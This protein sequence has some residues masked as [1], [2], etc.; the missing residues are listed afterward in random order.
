MVMRY[1]C[2]AVESSLVSPKAPMPYKR[3][4]S[5]S[6]PP[7]LIVSTTPLRN[8]GLAMASPFEAKIKKQEFRKMRLMSSSSIC[9]KSAFLI[10]FVVALL[11]NSANAQKLINDKDG[12]VGKRQYLLSGLFLCI[13]L[14]C[15]LCCIDSNCLC[16]LFL[17]RWHLAWKICLGSSL[18]NAHFFALSN[19]AAV[20]IQSSLRCWMV[21]ERT[22]EPSSMVRV[23]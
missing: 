13:T 11:S 5:V 14:I 4:A 8:Q 7:L 1:S 21:H 17:L 18:H 9:D 2:E 20:D 15:G 6:A 12:K 19:M 10:S 3:G 22:R 23:E 16:L